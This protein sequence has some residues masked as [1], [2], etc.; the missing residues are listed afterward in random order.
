VDVGARQGELGA[1]P[2]GSVLGGAFFEVT[3]QRIQV[4]VPLAIQLGQALQREGRAGILLQNA[5]VALDQ[6]CGRGSFGARGRHLGR[7]RGGRART[8]LRRSAASFWI[9]VTR[10]RVRSKRG[11]QQRERHDRRPSAPK[12]HASR[13]GSHSGRLRRAAQNRQR[14]PCLARRPVAL[15]QGPAAGERQA[16]A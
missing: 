16:I 5:L 1:A 2:G 13:E 6:R 14:F 4:A 12:P 15:E 11:M 8:A 10:H 7:C 3:D 9:E